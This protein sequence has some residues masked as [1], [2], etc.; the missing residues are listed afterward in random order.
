MIDKS[1]RLQSPKTLI[2]GDG[3]INTLSQLK[4]YKKLS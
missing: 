3:E 1:Y 2:H 4:E